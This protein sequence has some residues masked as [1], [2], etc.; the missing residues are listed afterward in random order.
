MERE[1]EQGEVGS[2]PM[3]SGAL[4]AAGSPPIRDASRHRPTEPLIFLSHPQRCMLSQTSSPA[5]RRRDRA[6]GRA[7]DGVA[8]RVGAVDA[9]AVALRDARMVCLWVRAGALTFLDFSCGLRAGLEGGA[10][11][12]V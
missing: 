8:R 6:P 5:R 3:R 7:S 9:G 12:G 1:R 10:L 4:L 2:D 11:P